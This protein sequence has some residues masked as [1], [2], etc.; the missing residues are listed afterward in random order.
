MICACA[1]FKFQVY[2]CQNVSIETWSEP[3]KSDKNWNPFWRYELNVD[4]TSTKWNA[5]PSP[6]TPTSKTKP[7]FLVIMSKTWCCILDTVLLCIKK[8]GNQNF[9][10]FNLRGDLS[11]S[12]FDH[13]R[14]DNRFELLVQRVIGVIGAYALCK[15]YKTLSKINVLFNFLFEETFNS[16]GALHGVQLGWNPQLGDKSRKWH[17]PTT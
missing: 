11:W 12:C 16:W 5:Y 14:Y 3:Q 4:W 2:G 8:I 6:P 9:R 1:C 15:F 7:F 17:F 13:H 10:Y